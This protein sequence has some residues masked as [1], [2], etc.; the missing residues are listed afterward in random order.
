MNILLTILLISKF[1][2]TKH[3]KRIFN[4]VKD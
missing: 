4:I 1:L 3:K 2:G